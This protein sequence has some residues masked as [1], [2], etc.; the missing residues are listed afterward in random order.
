MLKK[1]TL[2]RNNIIHGMSYLATT[3]TVT[4][5]S[6]TPAILIIEPDT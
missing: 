5:I 6:D 3:E 1:L 2:Q 4:L